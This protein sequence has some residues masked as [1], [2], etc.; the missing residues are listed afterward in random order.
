MNDYDRATELRLQAHQTYSEILATQLLMTGCIDQLIS[1]VY[2]ELSLADKQGLKDIQDKIF[3]YRII[4]EA[5]HVRAQKLLETAS[6]L[7]DSK[8]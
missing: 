2:V 7:D 4:M 3:G 5:M 6:S 1:T 8:K